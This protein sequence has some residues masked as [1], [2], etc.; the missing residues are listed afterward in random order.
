MKYGMAE[1]LFDEDFKDAVEG[2]STV[3]GKSDQS[4]SSG[5]PIMV[6][7]SNKANIDCNAVVFSIQF[8]GKIIGEVGLMDSD[9][10]QLDWKKFKEYLFQNLLSMQN[11]DKIC[12]M[13][14]DEEG[15]K[16]PIDCDEEYQEALKVAK[17][18]AE[19]NDKLVLDISRQG[20]LPTTV[21]NLASSAIKRVSSSPPKDGGLSFFKH[22]TS[23]PKENRSNLPPRAVGAERKLFPGF[24]MHNKGP[25]P[26]H[27][28]GL[29]EGDCD[30]A[31]E[32]SK[33]STSTT[34]TAAAAT[35]T[36]TTT[37]T[38]IA[39]PTQENKGPPVSIPKKNVPGM[40]FYHKD[41]SSNISESNRLVEGCSSSS[42]FSPPLTSPEHYR[43]SFSS[44]RHKTAPYT[45][46]GPPP[47]FITY[48]ENFRTCIS[49]EIVEKVSA[50]LEK[51]QYP[52]YQQQQQQNQHQQTCSE[53][54]DAVQDNKKVLQTN[55]DLIPFHLQDQ[56]SDLKKEKSQDE[57]DTE[58][59]KES[60]S[61]KDKK[62][63]KKKEKHEDNESSAKRKKLTFDEEKLTRKIDKMEKAERKKIGMKYQD[64]LDKATRTQEK[65]LAKMEGLRKKQS[66]SPEELNKLRKMV[67]KHNS[68]VSAQIR[69]NER[70]LGSL[71]QGR[72]KK[73]N[74]DNKAFPVDASLLHT[75]LQELEVLAEDSPG[76]SSGA[77]A[78]TRGFDATYMYDVTIPD[79]SCVNPGQEFVKTWK[80]SNSGV[81]TWNEK[82]MLCKWSQVHFCGSPAGWKLRPNMKKI[83]CPALEPGQMG[84][85]SI[86]FVAPSEPG[87]YAT[88]WRFCQRGR[89]FGNQM[90]CAV[91]VTEDSENNSQELNETIESTVDSLSEKVNDLDI[92]CQILNE[93]IETTVQTLS[94][95]VNYLDISCE[96]T[97]VI[98]DKCESTRERADG[99]EST[100]ESEVVSNKTDSRQDLVDL[101]DT[102]QINC[103]QTAI[104]DATVKEGST[105]SDSFSKL[106]IS[107][108]EDMADPGSDRCEVNIVENYYDADNTSQQIKHSTQGQDCETSYLGLGFEENTKGECNT[109][110]LK[111]LISFESEAE[112]L[113]SGSSTP[114]I[115]EASNQLACDAANLSCELDVL[116]LSS[117]SCS[118]LDSED[119]AIMNESD[120]EGSDQEY[121]LVNMPDCFNL[122]EPFKGLVISYGNHRK[123]VGS[124]D[125]CIEG[126][127]F[128]TDQDDGNNETL[129][130]HSVEASD[131]LTKENSIPNDFS[132]TPDK[133]CKTEVDCISESSETSVS[134]L[135]PD[136]DSKP[137]VK[138]H[139]PEVFQTTQLY[140]KITQNSSEDE[141]KDGYKADGSSIV[142]PTV[143]GISEPNTN[144][145]GNGPKKVICHQP[146]AV[147]CV[148]DKSSMSSSVS[149][150]IKPSVALREQEI[151]PLTDSTLSLTTERQSTTAKVLEQGSLPEELESII[152][153]DLVRGA[154][155]TARSFITRINK[156]IVSPGSGLEYGRTLISEDN[157][158]NQTTTIMPVQ[159]VT[160]QN[161]QF[162]ESFSAN[163][164]LGAGSSVLS[165]QQQLT[166]MGFVNLGVNQR[167]L[168]KYH[169]DVSKAVAELI[170]LN[171][172]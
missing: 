39:S 126:S 93:T 155:N 167:L 79:G 42:S 156:E 18:K 112:V 161:Q 97:E 150:E 99:I 46:E 55:T 153:E 101:L 129:S 135:D 3:E 118:E 27:V 65:V 50:R 166:D 75:A 34:T 106:D 48:M 125:E 109:N 61:R 143:K 140:Y 82:T 131:I 94:E 9:L 23:P 165:P 116:S 137:F 12:V 164:K 14:S 110:P 133:S 146:H 11:Q 108:S 49:E 114:E 60:N 40:L 76:E 66:C 29:W 85:I 147:Q 15:D 151:V 144:S 4:C 43:K 45:T 13:Y 47:W 134:E 120:S 117:E 154:W 111:D 115:I 122:D 16:L 123:N 87:W 103:E 86:T 121:Y 91:R 26:G 171:H 64:E 157:L 107:D 136:D 28:Q 149:S 95:K 68:R 104:E 172:R 170:V 41:W 33:P 139:H 57:N 30:E 119:Q 124:K 80:V 52:Q 89:V 54:V 25:V 160:D 130:C 51:Q 20:R 102:L 98:V 92:S 127:Y 83:V 128:V 31:L 158:G 67:D 142:D 35:K 72:N 36:T 63:R 19:S 145:W 5:T 152:P 6:A 58:D 132:G 38:P 77:G 59:K 62:M 8:Y 78:A 163:S 96:L 169:N 1:S 71:K 141:V 53:F 70:K 105:V 113:D 24:F 88:H 81:L 90:W 138:L 2:K 84:E 168:D 69:R 37:A 159:I 21:M 73:I 44:V 148:D 32:C 100:T 17:R 56:E 22:S 74:I 7:M 162:H 10:S